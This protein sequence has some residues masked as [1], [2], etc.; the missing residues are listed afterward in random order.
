MASLVGV[1]RRKR[2]R[3]WTKTWRKGRRDENIRKRGEGNRPEFADALANIHILEA[4]FFS[5]SRSILGPFWPIV[6]LLVLIEPSRGR[7]GCL[8]DVFGESLA[9][10]VGFL[11]RLSAPEREGTKIDENVARGGRRHLQTL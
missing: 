10:L 1:L 3:K 11:R 4:R 7:V 5:D 6:A 8:G 2:G 9:S